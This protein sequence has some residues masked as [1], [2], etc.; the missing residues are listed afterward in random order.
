VQEFLLDRQR[1]LDEVAT[2]GITDPSQLAARLDLVRAKHPADAA[3]GAQLDA[4]LESTTV[5]D[6]RL[7]AVTPIA[8]E[9][10]QPEPD[11]ESDAESDDAQA[12]A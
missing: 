12:A 8:P 9:T 3:R 10:A 5:T 6:A 2:S 1:V 11:T 7:T 4:M